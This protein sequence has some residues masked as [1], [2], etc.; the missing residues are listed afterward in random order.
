MSS[1]SRSPSKRDDDDG[2]TKE[3]LCYIIHDL[4]SLA[5]NTKCCI[6][7]RRNKRE[8]EKGKEKENEIPFQ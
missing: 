5:M 2:V 8:K 6:L 7:H 1:K 3:L 4:N